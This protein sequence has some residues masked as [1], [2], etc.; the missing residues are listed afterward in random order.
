M[1]KRV[2]CGIN[3]IMSCII[4]KFFF[5]KIFFF[6]M[7]TV[8]KVYWLCYSIVS[9]LFIFY[10]WPWACEIL[11]PPQLGMKPVHT[12][13]RHH[14]PRPPLL[15][16]T[17]GRQSFNHWTTRE[18][19]RFIWKEVFKEKKIMFFIKGTCGHHLFIMLHLTELSSISQVLDGML[20]HS[21]TLFNFAIYPEVL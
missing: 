5:F 1:I 4:F 7:W 17:I 18:V 15:T 12:H 21:E 3:V 14:Q 9:V 16:P 19:R 6:L 20:E 8:F 2:F 11:L 13:H 10:F